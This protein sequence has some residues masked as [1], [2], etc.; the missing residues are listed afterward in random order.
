MKWLEAI[1]W[2]P[3]IIGLTGSLWAQTANEP[4]LTLD[5]CITLAISRNPLVLSSL[6]KYNAAKARI[7]QAGEFSQPNLDF[8]SDLQP[9]LFDF[10]RSEESHFGFSQTLEFPGKIPV[11]KRIALREAD[12]VLGD[13]DLL[14]LDLVFQV[15]QSFFGVLLAEEGV[16]CARQDLELSQGFLDKV[17]LMNKA[18]DIAEVEVIRAKVEYAKAINSLKTAENEKRL[19]MARLN[20]LLAR[21]LYDPFKIEGSLKGSDIQLD[22]DKFKQQALVSRPEIRII[23]FSRQGEVLRKTQALLDYLPDFDLGVY[24]HRMAGSPMTWN[25]TLSLK[26]PL[27]FWQTKR[28]R[29]A[30]TE[31]NLRSIKHEIDHL[32]DSIILD[33]EEATLNAVTAQEQMRLF[34]EQVLAQAEEVYSIFLFKFQKGEIG[35]IELIEARRSMNESRRAY[36]ETLYNYRM[37]IAALEKSVGHSLQGDTANESN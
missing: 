23:E 19:A 21:R 20:Y 15:K 5:K 9:R 14:K 11:R 7:N 1:F 3:A 35:G 31:A 13:A 37:A 30:E 27:F 6:E 4:P 25:F 28:G 12:Q 18:G 36:A 24:K 2:F 32:H 10:R 22:V 17:E 26:I 34:N 8:D 33:V 29:V 16:T